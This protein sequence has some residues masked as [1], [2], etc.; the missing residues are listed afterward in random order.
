MIVVLALVSFVA[1]VLIQLPPGDF[2]K[3]YIQNLIASGRGPADREAYE[4]TL[5]KQYGLDQPFLV[6]YFKWVSRICR[7]DFGYSLVLG[8]PVN[9]VIAERLPLTVAV[10]ISTLL[11]T[12]V[13]AV[14]IGI[15]SATHQYSPSDFGL[16]FVGFIGLAI[17]N[18]FLALLLMYFFNAAFG[19]SVSGLFSPEYAVSSWS[20]A[21]LLDML[22]HLPIPIIVVATGGTAGLIR[23]MRATLLDELQKQYVV[24]ARSKGVS[25]RILLWRYPVRVAINPVISTVG[26]L[27]PA[28]VSGAEL[29]SIVLGLPTTGPVLLRALI[30]QDMY[31]AGSIVMML[32]GLTV[33][34]TAISDLLLVA[35]DPRIRFEKG[36]T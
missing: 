25:E 19:I 13:I 26:W 21:K 12:Y 18:F 16:M 15:Y 4:A 14:P 7:G 23:V 33:L 30:N 20:F 10:S 36:N 34:G 35:V 11:L 27:L 22:K 32:S 8:R 5:R 1:F 3:I 2:V 28:I 6:R 29:T 9:E 17:P 31:L 24:T